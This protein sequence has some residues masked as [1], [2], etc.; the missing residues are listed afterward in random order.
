[1][2][3]KRSGQGR[4]E[5]SLSTLKLPGSVT[6]ESLLGEE[7]PLEVWMVY[8][9]GLS[10]ASSATDDTTPGSLEDG[11]WC[12]VSVPSLENLVKAERT[13][14]TPK[15]LKLGPLMM[16][17]V[18]AIPEHVGRMET[19]SSFEG[20]GESPTMESM[21][22]DWNKIAGNFDT[23]IARMLELE[24]GQQGYQEAVVNTVGALQSAMGESDTR[25][26]F[27][28]A[29]LGKTTA[30]DEDY[31]TVWESIDFLGAEVERAHVAVEALE[32]TSG[33]QAAVESCLE[34]CSTTGKGLQ[35][36]KLFKTEVKQA[37]PK[38]AGGLKTLS[39]NVKDALRGIKQAVMDV[40]LKVDQRPSQVRSGSGGG[41]GIDLDAKQDLQFLRDDVT[42]VQNDVK[43][44]ERSVDL[45]SSASASVDV[46]KVM[47]RINEVETRVSGESFHEDGYSFGSVQDLTKW[48][49]AE[50]VPT[51][52]I[53][54][55]LFSVMT[56]MTP[57]S[58]TGKE[59]ADMNYS[60]QRTN[61]TTFENDLA[62]AMTHERPLCL[63]G[64]KDGSLAPL[65]VGFAACPSHQLWIGGSES[66]KQ[67]LG[68]QLNEFC[69]GVRGVLPRQATTMCGLSRTLL[70]L[71]RVEWGELTS[72]MDDF[73]TDLVE[74]AN[75][76][77]D[78]AWLLVARCVA[79]IYETMRPYRARVA[80]IETPSTMEAKTEYLWAVLQC[81]RVMS[82]FIAVDFRGHPMVVKA[83]SLF[84]ITEQVDPAALD[85]LELRVQKALQDVEKSKAEVEKL[86][87]GQAT[88]KRNYENLMADVKK[89]K[90]KVK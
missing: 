46:S 89:L 5:P 6:L 65:D 63:Y 35:S 20:D 29:R 44:L 72:F 45:L 58:L 31:S 90:E 68:R 24:T 74:V 57:K 78:K 4:F 75:F 18:D 52:G 37:L 36:L 34:Q 84:L 80:L 19:L 70:S 40:E 76:P 38:I 54:W 12:D 77:R 28:A 56:M 49:V 3:G 82:E 62:A 41:N 71:T 88:L 55:D 47:E 7:K 32:K 15:R 13:I 73:F 53:F 17:G 60:S 26:Q 69:Q 81:H 10:Q 21:Q 83:I 23:V 8:F 33:N 27:L 2:K 51:V 39:Q 11:S 42:D 30:K 50:R 9:A 22:A 59:R 16:A 61:T 1:M 66:Y 87:D 14:Q 64:K 43:G 67:K 25:L 79:A 85:K 86:K 48:V